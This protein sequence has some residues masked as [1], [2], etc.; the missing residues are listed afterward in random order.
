M[1]LPFHC[2]LFHRI[3]ESLE[4]EGTSEGHLVQLPCNEQGHHSYIRLPRALSSLAFKVSRDGASTTSLG[5]KFQCLTTLTVKIFLS[6]HFTSICQVPDIVMVSYHIL[7]TC[8]GKS[9]FNVKY[10]ITPNISRNIGM[11]TVLLV[12][13]I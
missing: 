3:I 12:S 4:L 9:I 2:P 7:H 1:P 13:T 10:Q 8:L 11:K 5:I 6:C